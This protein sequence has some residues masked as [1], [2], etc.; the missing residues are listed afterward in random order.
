MSSY[1]IATFNAENLLHPGVF[2][3]GRGDAAPYPEELFADKARWIAS[4]L[5]EGRVDLAGLQEVFSAEALRRTVAASGYLRG[6][7]VLAPG[8]DRGENITAREDGGEEATGPHVALVTRFPVLSCEAV[9]DFP[10][11]VQVP[12]QLVDHRPRDGDAA[13][14]AVRR[15]QR[16]VLRARVV[17]P[18]D[19]PATVLVAHLKSKRPKY[20]SDEDPRDPVAQ[21]A[22][23]VRSLTLRAVEAMALRAMVVSLLDGP[24]GGRGEPVLLLGDLNDDLTAVS[25]QVVAGEEPPRYLSA[26]RR[27]AASDV[28]LYSVHDIQGLRSYRDVA[29]THIH[30]GRYQLLDHIFVSQ[31]FLAEFPGRVGEVVST[32]V[33]NDHLH[34]ERFSAPR[35]RPGVVVDGE[36][37]WL[38]SARSDHGVPVTEVVVPE[39]AQPS[40]QEEG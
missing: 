6:A 32:R 3:A 29:Y 8:I 28:Q 16:P 19:V 23:R 24:D 7:S 25:T 30:D 11:H 12:V 39:P 10:G 37:L 13:D 20:L 4:V 33:F 22:G 5:D 36:T 34:D 31:E 27:L 15:F 17:L 18:G 1:R 14:G 21:A 9:R 26:Q 38:P 40:P 35:E 2:F